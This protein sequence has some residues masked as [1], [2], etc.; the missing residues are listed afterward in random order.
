MSHGFHS[1][2]NEI[3]NNKTEM[4]KGKFDHHHP[5]E[6]EHTTQYKEQLS[7][8]HITSTI[9]TCI[10]VAMKWASGHTQS[11]KWMIQLCEILNYLYSKLVAFWPSNTDLLGALQQ[12]F[13]VLLQIS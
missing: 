10:L 4:Y 5:Y 7:G 3:V 8:S 13:S 9:N 11:Y 6:Y 2:A 12:V 1:V